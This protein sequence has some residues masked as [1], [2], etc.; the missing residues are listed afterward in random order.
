MQ[1]V[2][3]KSKSRIAMAKSSFKKIN[4]SFQQQTAFKCNEE[5]TEMLRLEHSFWKALKPGRFGNQT[6]IRYLG[7][8]ETW[9]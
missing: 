3:V 6:E 9:C 4:N 1:G 2:N 8:F 5:T 7:S